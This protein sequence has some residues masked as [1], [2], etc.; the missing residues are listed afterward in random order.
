MVP[1]RLLEGMR[2]IPFLPTSCSA[3]L[4]VWQSHNSHCKKE[5]LQY[6]P[7]AVVWTAYIRDGL[8]HIQREMERRGGYEAEAQQSLS[9][10]LLRVIQFF[11]RWRGG[12]MASRP[13]ATTR[14]WTSGAILAT[15]QGTSPIFDRLV[16]FLRLQKQSLEKAHEEAS[17]VAQQIH[18]AKD[19]RY[20]NHFLT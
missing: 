13:S 3:A 1:L 16:N 10:L 2:A 4:S 18:E 8:H 12:G 6:L 9:I 5:G 19:A 15:H 17:Q 14:W 20:S 7:A 11:G